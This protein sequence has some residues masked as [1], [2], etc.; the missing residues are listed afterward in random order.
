MHKYM[1]ATTAHVFLGGTISRPGVSNGDFK[2][3]SSDFPDLCRIYREEKEKYI[4]QWVFGHCFVGV[5]FPKA[6]T[7]ELTP[8]E[9]R[10]FNT[11]RVQTNNQPPVKLDVG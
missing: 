11:Q 8:E 2:D 5:R 10:R 9:V 4:G 7:R 3:I 6:T 1:M